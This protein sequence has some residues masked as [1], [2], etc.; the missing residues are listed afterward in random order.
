MPAVKPKKNHP[1]K[2]FIFNVDDKSVR[3]MHGFRCEKRRSL[4]RGDTY[5]ESGIFLPALPEADVQD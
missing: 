2:K 5:E 3:D 1:W 4:K